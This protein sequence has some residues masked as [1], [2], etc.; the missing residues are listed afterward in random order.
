MLDKKVCHIGDEV[1]AVA[2]VDRDTAEAALELIINYPKNYGKLLNIHR[3][4]HM[5]GLDG[6]IYFNKKGPFCNL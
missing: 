2:A 5:E 6:W 1:A 3:E 4:M